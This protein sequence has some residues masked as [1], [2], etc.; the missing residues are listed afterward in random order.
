MTFC[1]KTK[2]VFRVQIEILVV[3]E[4]YFDIGIIYYLLADT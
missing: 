4:K 3:I 2:N 1:W